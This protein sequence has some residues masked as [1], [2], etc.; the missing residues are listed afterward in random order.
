MSRKYKTIGKKAIAFI[1]VLLTLAGFIPGSF[2]APQEASAQM[3]VLQKTERIIL[4]RTV[5]Q[6]Y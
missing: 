6:P 3:S 1:I 2:F 5:S 4:S